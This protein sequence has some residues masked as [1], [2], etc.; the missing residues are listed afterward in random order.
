MRV[1]HRAAIVLLVLIALTAGCRRETKQPQSQ[2]PLDESKVRITAW[3][4]ANAPCQQGTVEVLRDLEARHS[5][6]MNVRIINIAS[7]EGR[8]RWRNEGLDSAAIEINGNTT[9]A[10][11]EGDDRRTVSFMH[12]PGFTWTHE[13]LK[14]A[15]AAA[16][17]GQL[18]PADPAEAEGVRLMDVSVRGQ[19]IRVGD[20]G[21]ETGQLIVQDQV[22]LE[23][24]HPWN[25]EAPGRRVTAAANALEEVLE[26]PFTPN[27]LTL[28]PADDGVALMVGETL[29]L[30]AT[31]ADADEAGTSPR[32]LAVQWYRSLREALINAALRRPIAP[33]A[34]PESAPPAD[35]PANTLLDPLKPASP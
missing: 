4:D 21:A 28:Q 5:E 12:P 29:L 11:G 3:L 2:R 35:T 20:E 16:L 31:Q 19:S 10:W 26:E 6:R 15:I 14:A 25:D 17:Q 34:Q 7:P 13:D 32:E 27:Q 33:E 22:V 18:L 30:V 24:I 1:L 9:V 8:E 23:I